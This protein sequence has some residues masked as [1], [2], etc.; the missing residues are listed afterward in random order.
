MGWQIGCLYNQ[1]PAEQ[2]QLYFEHQ[3]KA[4]D[5]YQLAAEVRKGLD[6]LNT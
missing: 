2:P 6:L 1:E 3:F 5:P 4:G